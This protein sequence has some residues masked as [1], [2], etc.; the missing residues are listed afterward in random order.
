[1]SRFS[2]RAAAPATAPGFTP[3]PTYSSPEAIASTPPMTR[4]AGFGG[5][6]VE[7]LP[8]AAREKFR[9]LVQAADDAVALSRLAS[10]KNSEALQEKLS[11]TGN[12]DRY[13][14]E[15][16]RFIGAPRKP[17]GNVDFESD[18]EWQNLKAKADRAAEKFERT[19]ALSN[20]RAA[21]FQMKRGLAEKLER[22]LAG[23]GPET[24]FSPVEVKPATM[25]KGESFANV[26]DQ[27][28][29]D[30]TA[31]HDETEQLRNAPASKAEARAAAESYVERTIAAGKPDI[32]NIAR[33]AREAG[34]T[35]SMR[36]ADVMGFVTTEAGGLKQDPSPVRVRSV[37]PV[38]VAAWLDPDT[39]RSRILQ[40]IETTFSDDMLD[41]KGKA[42]R[43]AVIAG[44]IE[45]LER[46]EEATITEAE[47]A[48]VEVLRR[49]DANPVAVLCVTTS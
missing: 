9:R 35:W 6:P 45:Q 16:A 5:D 42:E 47:A 39:F 33:P 15:F 44:E 26:I 23:Y 37:D 17:D 38:A 21:T 18:H 28:R 1:M 41:A 3:G 7:R 10:E 31:R 46:V 11:A 27:I 13:Q 25:R 32:R 8:Y 29:A 20:E 2:P 19:T 24:T 36:P 40:E 14:A 43:L 48:G 30:I 4:I 22:W 12:L 49:P 34:V